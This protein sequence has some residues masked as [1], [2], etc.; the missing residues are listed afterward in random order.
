ME[1]PSFDTKL[2]IETTTIMFADVVESVRLIEQDETAS[3]VRLGS[4]LTLFFRADPPHDYAAARECDT[5]TFGRFHAGMLAK[6]VML[7]PSQFETWFV[8]AAHQ[9]ADIDATVN[10]AH[11][12]LRTIYESRFAADGSLR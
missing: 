11:E 9:E 10:A 3:V 6:G 7:P 12:V 8:S 2:H 1:A 5:V 4:M